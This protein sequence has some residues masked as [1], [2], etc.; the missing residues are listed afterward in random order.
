MV[1]TVSDHRKLT[2]RSMIMIQSLPCSCSAG[3]SSYVC[4]Y[5]DIC[6]YIYMHK[7]INICM[8]TLQQEQAFDAALASDSDMLLQ[9]ATVLKYRHPKH[10]IIVLLFSYAFTCCPFF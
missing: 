6:I 1:P 10:R 4:K 7:Y 3:S 9:S 5:T 8:Y 2:G